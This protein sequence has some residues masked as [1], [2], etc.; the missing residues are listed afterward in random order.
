[1]TVCDMYL[2]PRMT[3][4]PASAQLLNRLTHNNKLEAK[5][6]LLTVQEGVD[7]LVEVL[8]NR[9]SVT[10]LQLLSAHR[11]ALCLVPGGR[12]KEA[13]RQKIQQLVLPPR[14]G[15]LVASLISMNQEEYE[16]WVFLFGNVYRLKRPRNVDLAEQ[17]YEY[18]HFYW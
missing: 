6:F 11:V 4:T 13:A 9:Q 1:M 3:T 7:N 8:Y 10:P 5:K 17:M 14:M 12:G 16:E 15:K 18:Y 2:K